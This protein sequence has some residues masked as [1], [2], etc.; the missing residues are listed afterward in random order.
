MIFSKDH[1]EKI[2]DGT[3]TQTRRLKSNY[4]IGRSYAVQ[5]GRGK[6]AIPDMRIEIL[7]IWQEKLG[8]ISEED[9]RE[10][11]YNS[12]DEYREIW[13]KINKKYEPDQVVYAIKFRM[14]RR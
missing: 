5:P 7:D 13:A 10:E 11:G 3:K 4:K 8:E 14:C 6:R 1:I 2:R 12:S 9:C